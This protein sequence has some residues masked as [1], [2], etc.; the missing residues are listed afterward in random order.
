MRLAHERFIEAGENILALVTLSGVAKQSRAPVS[1]L[2]VHF[3]TVEDR[4]CGGSR[5]TSTARR[6][7]PR[8]G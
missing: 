7:S 8:P 3:W 2:V 6:A 1:A 5:S 4:R